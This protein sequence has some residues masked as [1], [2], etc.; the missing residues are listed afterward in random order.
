MSEQSPVP[1]H[2]AIPVFNNSNA[3]GKLLS[4]LE[5]QNFASIKILDDAS[6]DDIDEVLSKYPN[7]KL[8]RA[9]ENGDTVAA[10]NMILQ[11]MPSDGFVLF[12]DSDLQI[13]TANIPEK[14]GEFINTHPQIGAGAGQILDGDGQTTRWNYNYDLNPWRAVFAFCTYHPAR[15]LAPVPLLGK[16]F[17]RASYP[18]TTHLF[19]DKDRKVDWVIEGFCFFRTDLFKQ[20]GGYPSVYKRFHEGPDLCLQLRKAGYEVWFTPRITVQNLDQ[21]SGSSR[22]RAYHWFRSTFIYFWRHPSR[23]LFYCWTRP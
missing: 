13:V 6:T 22:H 10:K 23:L 12:I 16:L 4:T 2:A 18:F 7:V 20:F 9:Q 17:A 21:H 14:L 15:L 8:V 5:Q 19:E 11:Q 1:I 3:I